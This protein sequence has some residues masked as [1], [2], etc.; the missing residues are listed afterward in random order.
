M[1]VELLLLRGDTIRDVLFSY[2]VD[3]IVVVVNILL[4]I[5]IEIFIKG[6]Y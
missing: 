5:N 1:N 2:I 4:I 6:C 3:V